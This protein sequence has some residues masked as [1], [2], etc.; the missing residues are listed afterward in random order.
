M[1]AVGVIA[2][3][4]QVYYHFR[5]PVS[6]TYH[7]T[8]MALL[9][10]WALVSIAC[11]WCLRRR[12]HVDAIRLIWLAADAILLTAVLIVDEAY[13]SS[14]ALTYG[15]FIV[16]SGLWF[17]AKIVWVATFLA[18]LGYVVLVLVGVYRQGFGVSPQHDVMVL[19]GLAIMGWLVAAQVERVR[20]L[21]RYYENRPMP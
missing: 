19:A 11:Q 21:S 10:L 5:H 12:R 1:G 2:A 14:L 17:R 9:A 13:Y 4:A 15:I 8:I 20:V 7:I 6:L 18:C 3:I 16:G